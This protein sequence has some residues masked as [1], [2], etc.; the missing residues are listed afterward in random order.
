[1]LIKAK[2]TSIITTITCDYYS[3]F[4]QIGTVIHQMAGLTVLLFLK[5]LPGAATRIGLNSAH[6]KIAGYSRQ[7][8]SHTL[9]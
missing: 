9:K 7:G 8:P 2:S 3:L 6:P 1:M 4:Y 5:F